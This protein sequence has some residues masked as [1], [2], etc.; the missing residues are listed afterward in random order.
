[1][2]WSIQRTDKHAHRLTLQF[3]T[4]NSTR[5]VLLLS[6]LHWD[7]AKCNRDLLKRHLDQALES[8]SPVIIAGDLFCAM[9]GKY[10]LRSSPSALRD[11]HRDNYLDSIVSTAVEWFAPYA[12]VLALIG[13]GNH[14][15][16]I[17]KRHEVNLSERLVFGLRM[18]HG[19]KVDLGQ[20]WGFVGLSCKNRGTHTSKVLHYHHGFGGGGEATHGV[21][22]WATYRSQYE[23]DVYLAGHVHHMNQTANMQ[24]RLT[25]NG[26][27]QTRHQLF[28][29]SSTYKD[30]RDGWHAEKGRAARPMGGWWLELHGI[31]NKSTNQN[32][33]IQ[34]RAVPTC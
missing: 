28:L 32:M 20:Y 8:S 27:V 17:L 13:M 34:M 16:A 22:Q 1:M 10:D 29:R 19:S 23:A 12:S 24:T 30:D 18:M 2:S 15:T 14:E 6:D 26:T 33:V 5:S 11:E 9:Q 21:T 7:N 4:G 3:K 25:I 31:R